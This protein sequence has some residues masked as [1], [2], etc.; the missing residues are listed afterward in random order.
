MRDRETSAWW[1]IVV[2]GPGTNPRVMIPLAKIPRFIPQT[3]PTSPDRTDDIGQVFFKT[4]QIRRH[5]THPTECTHLIITRSW[6]RSP[7]ALPRVIFRSYFP[8][9]HRAW[10]T[11]NSLPAS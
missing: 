1:Q 4:G 7:P 3:I 10:R 8:E 6:V 2:S 5:R 9:W 11:A